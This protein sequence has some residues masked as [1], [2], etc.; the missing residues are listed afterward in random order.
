MK[1]TEATKEKIRQTKL[2]NPTRY[3]LG[4]KRSPETIAK[5]SAKLKGRSVWNK[6]VPNPAIRGENNPAKRPEVKAKISVALL[7]KH[8]TTEAIEKNRAWHI[9]KHPAPM[10]EFVGT[11]TTFNGT[12]KEYV[13]LHN[14]VRA[15]LGKPKNCEFCKKYVEGPGIHWANKSRKYKKELDDWLRLCGKCHWEYDEQGQRRRISQ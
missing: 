1:H 14:W 4:K 7:G 12:R 5:V 8:P 13:N 9:G 11:G 6:G 3:W 2:A 10:T 15:N